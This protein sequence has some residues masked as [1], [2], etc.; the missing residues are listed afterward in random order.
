MRRPLALLPLLV[1]AACIPSRTIAYRQPPPPATAQP[2]WAPPTPTPA[3]TPPPVA[4][5]QPTATPRPT[6]GTGPTRPPFRFP[7]VI[8][9]TTPTAAPTTTAPPPSRVGC[10]EMVVDGASIP[11]DCFTK[12][13]AHIDGVA[14]APQA[15]P[16]KP[17]VEYI[18][19]RID[20]LEGP[21]RSQ[22][23]VGDSAALAVA[24]AIDRSLIQNGGGFYPVSA[25][26][27]WARSPHA[28]LGSLLKASLSKGI[29]AESTLPYSDAKA[30]AW[31]STDACRP[32]RAETPVAAETDPTPFARLADIQELDGTSGDALRDAILR[33]S[34]VLYALRVD[35]EAW[36]S[37]IKP[38]DAEPLLPD[39]SGT[40]LAHT[41]TLV[42]FALQDN[43]WFYLVKNS[44]GPG[45]GRDGYAWVQEQ[46]L[47][48]NYLG[49]FVVQATLASGPVAG[50]GP[51]SCPPGLRADATTGQC[52]TPCPDQS[53]RKGGACT[54][55]PKK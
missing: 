14:R 26:N 52:T 46:T 11:I 55:P 29:A 3:P 37:V 45:W 54:P 49:A 21:V 38:Q 31:A 27:L 25:L 36:K 16:I 35:A 13:Y 17:V 39:Y 50:W 30:C 12:D 47:K 19:H 18:D 15:A 33:G 4:T 53:P 9:A 23:A 51:S 20:R 22:R 48:R 8:I 44:W 7:R 24:S 1:L 32:S 34:D 43:S 2:T 10:G 6:T 5:A 40:T 42:G 28:Q 41:V